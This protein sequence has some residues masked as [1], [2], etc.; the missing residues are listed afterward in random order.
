MKLD[1][2]YFTSFYKQNPLVLL[3]IYWLV[4]LFLSFII[5]FTLTDE[6]L[7]IEHYSE[8]LE[9]ERIIELLEK[10]KLYLWLSYLFQFTYFF[11]KFSI[12]TLVVL[13]GLFAW[14]IKLDFKTVWS[15]VVMSETIFLITP[16]VKLFW[17]GFF[18]RD[19]SLSDLNSFAP[20]S[21]RAIFSIESK[22]IVSGYLLSKGNLLE[23]LYISFMS[24]LLSRAINADFLKGL[25][26]VMSSYV[27]ALFLW[28]I[29]ISF[30]LIILTT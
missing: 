8:T 16:F 9:Y 10:Q 13:S 2:A 11:V 27:V 22:E 29:F 20:F 12:I 28:T 4:S 30:L 25:K 3:I 6:M 19:Y 15:I 21:V 7:F 14:N 5:S 26:I 1:S 17:F 24:F 23:L 18:D